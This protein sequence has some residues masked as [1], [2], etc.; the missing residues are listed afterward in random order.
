MRNVIV[1]M[2]LP[3]QLASGTPQRRTVAKSNFDF[4]VSRTGSPRTLIHSVTM[5]MT[6]N[7]S[8]RCAGPDTS[9]FLSPCSQ[10]SIDLEKGS[11][12]VVMHV[13]KTRS[14]QR[15]EVAE[16]AAAATVGH[17]GRRDVFTEI[18]HVPSE[19]ANAQMVGGWGV[20]K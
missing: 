3:Q 1:K 15:T 5:Y 2:P 19:T 8:S 6:V 4:A 18:H 12:T 20:H 16:I 10:E 13:P 14:E 9:V 17:P 11:T 7:G